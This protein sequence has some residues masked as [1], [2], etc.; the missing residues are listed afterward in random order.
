M[1]KEKKSLYGIQDEYA[2][3]INSIID[4]EGEITP[5]QEAA[6]VINKAE[7][8]K[9]SEGYVAV[10]NRI[11][12]EMAYIDNETK[13]LAIMKRVRK[14]TEDRLKQTLSDA[15]NLYEIDEIKTS[16]NKINF[17]KSTSVVID[18]SIN[19]LPEEMKI[20]VEQAIPKAEI[21]KMLENGAEV[22]GVRLQSNKNI[23]IR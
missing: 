13:R 3:L 22:E 11:K 7:L 16:L 2:L 9:K 23:Q 20:Y 8:E 18:C 6:L 5:E 1:N 17:R 10:I 12:A 21:K 4:A 15:M 19:D 14:N